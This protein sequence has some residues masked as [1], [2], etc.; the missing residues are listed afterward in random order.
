MLWNI[1]Y[2]RINEL[3]ELTLLLTEANLDAIHS[4]LPVFEG[5]KQLQINEGKIKAP[6]LAI[7]LSQGIWPAKFLIGSTVEIP[8]DTFAFAYAASHKRSFDKTSRNYKQFKNTLC[9]PDTTPTGLAEWIILATQVLALKGDQVS[10]SEFTDGFTGKSWTDIHSLGALLPISGASV[11]DVFSWTALVVE[12]QEKDGALSSVG[13]IVNN[14]VTNNPDSAAE[15]EGQLEKIVNDRF[16]RTFFSAFLHGLK[17]VQLHPTSYY[18][19]LIV[20]F[21]IKEN[22]HFV[23]YALGMIGRENTV[24]TDSFFELVIDIFNNGQLNI[25][26]FISLCSNLKIYRKELY[27]KIEDLLPK[28]EDPDLIVAINNLLFMDTNK[29][30]DK[31]W[32]KDTAKLLMTK[33]GENLTH[34]LDMLLHDIVKSDLATAYDLLELRFLAMGPLH[35]L[36]D[37]I[38]EMI[39][40]DLALFQKQLVKW[41][42]QEDSYIH[43]ALRHI[44]SPKFTDSG[45]CRLPVAVFDGVSEHDKI[46][47]A[48]KIAGYVYSKDQMQQL[49]LSVIKS[50]TEAKDIVFAALHF[51]MSEYVVYNYRTTLDMMRQELKG[52]TELFD[53][54]RRLFTQLIEEYETYFSELKTIN[55]KKELAP[56][57]EHQMFKSF[58]TRKKFSVMPKE[59]R[60]NSFM[61]LFK[62][63]QLNSNKWAVRRAG[64]PK[65]Q[66][67]QLGT[68]SVSTEFPSGENLDPIQQEYMR[69]TY[70]K[71]KKDEINID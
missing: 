52:G 19:S 3:T 21:I 60:K 12:K 30:I 6:A 9:L 50:I 35:L 67:Q 5:M 40:K 37:S 24:E 42:I 38:N 2:G 29:E 26:E 62:S 46:Y 71:L 10:W 51:I 34:S 63:T 66:V 55:A 25:I 54:K 1:P 20:P 68:I 43:L 7:Y 33:S 58:Y 56:S 39:R 22:A 13:T 65:H 32:A 27:K 41:F 69:R 14:W 8:I 64:Q 47:M 15:L 45:Q 31:I 18:R 70:Q 61:N 49:E 59:A 16:L 48:Y 53:F 4:K 17:I 36:E 57:K 28:T 23:L 44:C 11:S